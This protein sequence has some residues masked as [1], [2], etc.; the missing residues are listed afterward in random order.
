MSSTPF[1]GAISYLLIGHGLTI[2]Y[3]A[4]P[5]VPFR[6]HVIER[7]AHST[8]KMLYRLR[9]VYIVLHIFIAMLF[10]DNLKRMNYLKFQVNKAY[11]D[12][13]TD[14]STLSDFSKRLHKAQRDFYILAFTLFCA[15][16][17][18]LLHLLVL[19]MEHYRTECVVTKELCTALENRN[20]VLTE[21]VN[22]LEIELGKKEIKKEKPKEEILPEYDDSNGLTQ[23]KNLTKDE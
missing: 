23:R 5:Y 3:L 22:H 8:S 14:N 9:F 21:N 12:T 11:E 6:R 20:R 13:R 2:T 4:L 15:F 18:Y 19:K 1:I 16:I 10:I 7:L 17:T